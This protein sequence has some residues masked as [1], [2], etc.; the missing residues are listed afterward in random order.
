MKVKSLTLSLQGRLKVKNIYIVHYHAMYIFYK[1]KSP[2][3]FSTDKMSDE[4]YGS[5]NNINFH[6]ECKQLK[7]H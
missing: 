7:I 5:L 1:G 3:F 2:K 4:I 6:L